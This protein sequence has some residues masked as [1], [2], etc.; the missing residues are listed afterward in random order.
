M[1]LAKEGEYTAIRDCYYSDGVYRHKF[2]RKWL[3]FAW[4]RGDKT[5]LELSDGIPIF[6][7]KI[8][9]YHKEA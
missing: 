8:D 3:E 9:T 6:P 2:I 1:T 5:C 7:N 4:D